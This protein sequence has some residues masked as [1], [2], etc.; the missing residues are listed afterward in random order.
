MNINVP[1]KNNII[2]DTYAKKARETNKGYAVKSFP[3]EISDIPEETKSL[4]WTFVDYDSIPVCGFAYIHWIVANVS[5][6]T[7][8]VP[9]DFARLDKDHLQGKNSLVSRFLTRDYSDMEEGYLGPY[10]PDKD[11]LYTLNVYALDK[12]LSLKKGFYLN[13]LLHELEDHVIEKAKIDLV[14]KF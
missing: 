5:P 7:E 13:E 1:F 11:H 3:F 14:G 8:T 2:P 4:A 9:E 6:T 10:P 12:E